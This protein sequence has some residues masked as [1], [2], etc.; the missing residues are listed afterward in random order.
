VFGTLIGALVIAVIQNGMNLLGVTSFRQRI[1]LG[2]IIIAAVLFDR[3][4]Q[5]GWRRYRTAGAARQF[6]ET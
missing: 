2:A 5:Y 3:A 4:K 1:V 6:G